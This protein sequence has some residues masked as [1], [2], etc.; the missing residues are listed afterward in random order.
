MK[1]AT[2]AIAAAAL[3]LAGVGSAAAQQ[4]D[5]R[6]EESARQAGLL[7]THSV[8]YN[9]E[10]NTCVATP[11]FGRGGVAGAT[12]AAGAAGAG[13]AAGTLGVAGGVLAGL[14]AISVAAVGSTGGT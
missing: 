1:S 13:G 10:N 4:V 7:Q 9:E 14:V 5:E 2:T 8:V 6:C 11:L 12:G 3:M